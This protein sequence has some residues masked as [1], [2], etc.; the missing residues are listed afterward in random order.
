MRSKLLALMGRSWCWTSVAAGVFFLSGCVSEVR[1][2]TGNEASFG[3]DNS[4]V[5]QS[6]PMDDKQRFDLR[7]ELAAAYYSGGQYDVAMEEI[8]KA[9]VVQPRSADANLLKGMIYDRQGNSAVALE[10]VRKAMT[11]KPGDGNY[12]HNYGVALCQSKNYAEGIK[13]LQQAVAVPGY[14]RAANSWAA[15][16]SCYAAA[17]DFA[18]A[19]RALRQSL[20]V[21][22]RNTMALMQL[23]SFMYKKNDFA[24]AR[25]YFNQL[26]PV[27][28]Q[29]ASTLWLGIRIARKQGDAL[30][31][32]QLSRLLHENYPASPECRALDLGD[33]DFE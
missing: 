2:V 10:Y 32:S 8:D 22:P 19:E 30:Y 23:A 31:G 25:Q 6:K 26:G 29:G 15:M 24:S 3:A 20:E 27:T 17:G 18:Q 11:Y 21:E 9:L 16:G 28:D 12:I 14:Q 4:P 7:F 33:F 1:T 5:T 13:Y